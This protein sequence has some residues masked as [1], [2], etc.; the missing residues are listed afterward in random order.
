MATVASVSIGAGPR[1]PQSSTGFVLNAGATEHYQDAD[2]Y[3]RRYEARSEDRD[4]YLRRAAKATS[5]LEY[6]AGTGRLTLPL[7]L[8]G[9]QVTAVDV[10]EPMLGRLRERASRYDPSVR[11]R[12]TLRASDMRTFTT[13]RRFD[14]VVVGFNALGHLYS[15]RDVASFLALALRHLHPGGELLLDLPMPHLDLPGYDPTAQIQV[16]EMEA[17]SGSELLTLR[18]FQPQELLMHLHYAGFE[19]AVLFGDFEGHPLETDSEVMVLVARRP[20]C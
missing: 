17:G 16:S 1:R 20:R 3:D 11:A 7:L 8:A 14:Q 19:R 15:H 12:L 9:K 6:G 5:I 13:K 2:S 18:L 4:F 10:S